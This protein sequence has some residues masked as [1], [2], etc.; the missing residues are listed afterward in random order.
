MLST[1]RAATGSWVAKLLLGLLVVS[2]AV[3]GISGQLVGGLGTGKVLTAGSTSVSIKDYRLAYDRQVSIISQQ[4]GQRLTR[5]QATA[6][7][8]DQQVLAQLVA[9]AVLDEQARQMGL[10]LSKDRLA[11]LTREDPAFAGPGGGFDRQRFDY[12]LREVGMN[13]EDYLTNRQQVA[14][15]QQIVEA[16]SDGLKAPDVFLSAL[17][18]Y[19]GEDRT[20]EYITLPNALVEPIKDPTDEQLKSWF[21]EH[22]KDYAAPEYRKFSYAKLEPEDIADP[23]AVSEEDV[24]KDYEQNKDRFTTPEMRTIEQVTFK[25]EDEAKA[26][27]ASLDGGAKFEDIIKAQ[28]KTPQDVTLGTF[29]KD[30]VPD[31][32]IAGPA[33]SLQQNQVSDVIKGAFG[34]VLVRITKIDPE[35]VKPLDAVK[36]DIRKELATNEASRVLLDVHDSYEDARAGGASLKEA[37]DKLGLKVV[38]IDADRNAQSPDGSI[39]K[40]LPASEE[41][42]RAVFDTEAD[43][44]NSPISVG[45]NGFVFYE[46]DSITAA[47]DRTLD[48]VHDKAL[49]DWRIEETDNLLKAKAE[50]LQKKIKDGATLDAI[51]A[52][53]SLEKQTKR[54]L[55][56][57][58]DDADFGKD[59]IAAVFFMPPQ[60]VGLTAA[61]SGDAQI[62]F[63]VTESFE[64][65]AS[66][67]DAIPPEAQ[68]SFAQGLSDDLLDQLV[69]KLQNTYEVT[70]DRNAIAQAMTF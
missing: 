60:A 29:A 11:K 15:R 17:A 49:A 36:D 8:L 68:R 52:E 19:Q 32:A 50:E 22:K 53:L 39:V 41:L 35:I 6:L 64:P 4:Y 58:A 65:A 70:I 37:A 5:E 40:D 69:T 25:N 18:L 20:A 61:P 67:A 48:E 57:G 30:K 42:I 43:V 44:E 34:P 3:W 27:R 51:A 12:V 46:V 24:A 28:G 2:F 33:F 47:R 26:A 62:L 31:P 9:G 45:S 23:S 66:G 56:R 59:G 21:E 55:K 38:T 63:K 1:L 16:V 14:V 13:A 7:G 10:G 54:G